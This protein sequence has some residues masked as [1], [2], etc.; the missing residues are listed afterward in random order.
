MNQIYL[1]H[2]IFSIL[3]GRAAAIAD[4]A[5]VVVSTDDM[6]GI[7]TQEILIQLDRFQIPVIFVFTKIDRSTSNI[8]LVKQELT[9]LCLVS[10]VTVIG[11][12][13]FG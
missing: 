9:N 4:I 1:G 6:P 13:A 11:A 3:R 7:Q 8:T 10:L 2:S 12:F 5:L